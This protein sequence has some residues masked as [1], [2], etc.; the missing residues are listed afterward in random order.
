MSLIGQVVCL[1]GIL[2]EVEKVYALRRARERDE[3][4]CTVYRYTAY[5]PGRGKLVR[6]DNTHRDKPDEFHRHV[7]D[8]NTGEQTSLTLLTREDFPV[9]TEVLDEV[10]HLAGEAGLL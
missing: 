4:R 9:L 2:L 8:L 7:Y 6:Y 5:V 1:G 10:Q 3:I